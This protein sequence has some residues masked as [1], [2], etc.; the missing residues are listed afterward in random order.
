M[1]QTN[2]SKKGRPKRPASACARYNRDRTAKLRQPKSSTV[3]GVFGTTSHKNT[4]QCQF[5]K[6][7]FD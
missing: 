3:L 2:A 5:S 6:L 1:R 7:K 4:A